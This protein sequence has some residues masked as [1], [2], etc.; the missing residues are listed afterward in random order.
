[1]KAMLKNHFV[2]AKVEKA[3]FNG[4]TFFIV[5]TGAAHS[6]FVLMFI[7]YIFLHFIGSQKQCPTTSPPGSEQIYCLI[8]MVTV[9]FLYQR[10]HPVFSLWLETV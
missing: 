1:M 7:P 4:E 9:H 8:K 2:F 6:L 10:G 3:F 5:V